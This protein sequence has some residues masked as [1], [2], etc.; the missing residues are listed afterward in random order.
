MG[1]VMVTIAM[2]GWIP[3]VL[4]LFCLLPARRAVLAAFVIAW[5]F[6]P[7]ASYKIPMF[8]PFTKMTAATLG[9]LIGVLLFDMRRLATYRLSWI[10]APVI[11]WCVAK[12]GASVSNGIGVYDGLSAI[13]GT[14]LTWGVPW[15]LGRLYFSDQEGMRE[16]VWAIVVGGLVYVPF[17]LVEVKMSPQFH[18]WVYG[19]F[20]HDFVQT[21]R[22]GGWR[23]TVFMQ[24]GLMVGMWMCMTG[25]VAWWMWLNKGLRQV[26]RM[27]MGV[28]AVTILAT[29]IMCKSFGAVILL[30][31]G[32][33]ALWMARNLKTL[34]PLYVLLILA[35]LY[36]G[37]RL[38]GVWSGRDMLT[39]SSSVGSEE[40]SDSLKSRLNSED[41][42]IRAGWQKPIFGFRG[43]YN[44][45]ELWDRKAKGAIP[46]ALW[47]IEFTGEGFFGLTALTLFLLLPPLRVLLRIRPSHLKDPEAAAA[48]A[49]AGVCILYMLDNLYNGMVNPIFALGAGAIVDWKGVTDTGG[50]E[51]MLETQSPMLAR[52]WPARRLALSTRSAT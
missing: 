24:H 19:Y 33:A 27:P 46:D 25:L 43:W 15:F 45:M 51:E 6:L 17:C 3:V 40:R 23:P 26:W 29:A 4:M 8:P 30:G 50:A 22:M 1:N 14:L 20:Q 36:M 34:V 13:E 38:G 39:A 5:L 52:Q 48:V 49:L 7:M 32:M 11:L 42:F 35:P 18:T 12:M 10:D 9:S 16:L 44:T 28:V 2:V 47:M 21:K 41:Q 31:M 37:T